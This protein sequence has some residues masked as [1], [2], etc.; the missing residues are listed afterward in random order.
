MP[1]ATSAKRGRSD[2][3]VNCGVI[4]P[5]VNARRSHLAP[6]VIVLTEDHR[7]DHP[8][9]GL[10]IGGGNAHVTQ[11]LRDHATEVEASDPLHYCPD[12]VAFS[13]AASSDKRD[14]P[15]AL[16]PE[17]LPVAGGSLSE[18]TG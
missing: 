7:R 15:D 9:H 10:E 6:D 8:G 5:S 14:F 17:S 2:S 4:S 1:A 16:V 13:S 12:L 3:V 18:Q 11:N